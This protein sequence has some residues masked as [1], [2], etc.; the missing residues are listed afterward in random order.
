M[1]FYRRFL[2]RLEP[3]GGFDCSCGNRHRIGTRRVLMGEGVLKELPALLSDRYGPARSAP[4]VWVLS[5]GNTEQAA[6]ARCKDLLSGRE[7]RATVL[8]AAPKPRPTLE[9]AEQLTREA[10]SH[11]P[12]L[13]LAVGSGVISDFGKKVAHELGIPSWCVGT[14]SS[15]DA[16]TSGNSVFKGHSRHQTLWVTPS[17]TVIC[18]LAVMATAPREMLL[19]GLGDLLAKFLA[20]LDWNLSARITGEPHCPESAA[21][22]RE[23]ALRPLRLLAGEGSPGSRELQAGL[24][25]ALLTTGFLMQALGN[26][27]PASSAEHTASFI[28][29]IAHLVGAP[30]MELHGLLVALASRFVLEVYREFYRA[31]PELAPDIPARVRA[32][33]AEPSWEQGLD[34]GM[35]IFAEHMRSEMSAAP[36]GPEAWG[37]RL[38]AFEREREDLGELAA[39]S[40]GD[41]EQ[42]I[43]ALQGVGLP[44]E[45]AAFRMTPASAYLPFPYLRL[46]RNRYNTFWLMHELGAE[47]APLEALR[48]LLGLN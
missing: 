17:E 23:S 12:G 15:V 38:S 8:P 3:D 31:L 48:L 2:E 9:L 5:D 45:P 40:L 42:G 20:N 10:A 21:I 36:Q 16:Y 19:S 4:R 44:F 41:L 43:A 14:A 1:D 25:D 29:E 11:S 26:S 18:D 24:T 47:Q 37:R 34:P 30:E 39:R 35:S 33:E 7:L 22:A 27:R 32:L 6:G 13:V 28:W 46:L